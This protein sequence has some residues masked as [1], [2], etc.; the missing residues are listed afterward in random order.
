[1]REGSPITRRRLHTSVRK[2][3]LAYCSEQEAA[4]IVKAA[5][6]L[7]M[8]TSNFIA[9]AALKEAE[10]TNSKRRKSHLA[11]RKRCVGIDTAAISE[12]CDRTNSR[13]T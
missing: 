11:R 8:T 12:F 4:E 10:A 7:R 13:I 2:T 6:K 3:L 9:S 1:V 5:K